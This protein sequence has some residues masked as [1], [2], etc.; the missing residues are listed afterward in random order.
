MERAA[1]ASAVEVSNVPDVDMKEISSS[2]ETKENATPSHQVVNLIFGEGPHKNEFLEIIQ[3]KSAVFR[4]Q[5]DF[6]VQGADNLHVKVTI[7]VSRQLGAVSVKDR[8]SSSGT[9]INGNKIRGEKKVH[10]R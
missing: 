10:S 9:F 1:A 7:Q 3:G 4:S 2:D 5:A 6:V 8:C